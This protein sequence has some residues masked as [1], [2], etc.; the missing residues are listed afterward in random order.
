MSE[1]QAVAASVLEAAIQWQLLLDSGDAT[2]E[3]QLAWQNWLAAHPDHERV[4]RQLTDLDATLTLLP[5]EAAAPVRQLLHKSRGHAVKKLAGSALGIF[6]LVCCLA[7]LDRH[8]PLY[9]L[10]ADYSTTTGQQQRIQLPDG[11]V[12]L[13]NT[14]TAVDIQFDDQHRAIHLRQGE[15][16]VQ[17][18][19]ANPAEQ[20]PLIVTTGEGSIR[21]LGTRFVV[22]RNHRITRVDVTEAAILARPK[23]C[24]PAPAIVCGNEHRVGAGYGVQLHSATQTIIKPSPAGVD[25]WPD[26]LLVVNDQ[27]LDTVVAELARYRTGFI[28]VSAD[29]AQLRMTGTL[30]IDDIDFALLALTDALPVRI[31]KRSGLWIHIEAK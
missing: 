4:W 23:H 6:S 28:T 29:V 13:L 27:P 26:G 22:Q 21:A 12:L 9:G 1:Q 8:Q 31:S 25:A 11:T 15:V 20:R 2:A 5:R 17:S 19:H 24:S 7:I 16:L 3:D 30:P 10:L 18:G 14:R